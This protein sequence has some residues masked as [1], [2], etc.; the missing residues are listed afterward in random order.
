MIQTLSLSMSGNFSDQEIFGVQS[1][2][3]L[4]EIRCILRGYRYQAGDTALLRATKPDDTVCYLSGISDGENVF[5]FLLTEQITAVTGDVRCDVSLCRGAGMI[6]S[7]QFTLKVR[8]PSAAGAMTE[9]ESE[10]LGFPDLI[11][12][13]IN[14]EEITFGEIDTLWKE[15]EA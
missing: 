2:K 1:D 5:R 13:T 6:S 3:D 8:P 11:L 15:A 9:S 12:N 7:D 14:A 4:S 10:Y